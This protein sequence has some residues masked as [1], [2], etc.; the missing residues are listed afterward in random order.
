MADTVR[1]SKIKNTHFVLL[2]ISVSSLG[3]LRYLSTDVTSQQAKKGSGIPAPHSCY[4]LYLN[5]VFF[6]C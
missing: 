1:K 5:R 2:K 6:P 4:T 3:H